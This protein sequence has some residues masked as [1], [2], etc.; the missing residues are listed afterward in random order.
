MVAAA[1]AVAA[2]AAA[3]L[4]RVCFSFLIERVMVVVVVFGD[5]AALMEEVRVGR[6]DEEG[7]SS[8]IFLVA[9]AAMGMVAWLEGGRRGCLYVCVCV[10]VSC[11]LVRFGVLCLFPFSASRK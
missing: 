3:A 6:A 9:A 1:A 5:S 2:V 7:A 8:L 10:Y 4:P 11:L